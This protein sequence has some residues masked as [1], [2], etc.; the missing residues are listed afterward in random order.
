MLNAIL[1]KLIDVLKDLEMFS[2]ISKNYFVSSSVS[3]FC[4][5]V[6]FLATAPQYGEV[7]CHFKE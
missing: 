2:S 1:Q 3:E 5:Q 4:V 7:M 6:F